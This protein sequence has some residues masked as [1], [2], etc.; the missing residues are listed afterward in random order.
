MKTSLFCRILALCLMLLWLAVLPAHAE[1]AAT[2]VLGQLRASILSRAKTSY[3]EF[4]AN[5]RISAENQLSFMVTDYFLSSVDQEGAMAVDVLVTLSLNPDCQDAFYMAD[6]DFVLVAFSGTPKTPENMLL[7]TPAHVFDVTNERDQELLWP[8]ALYN[9]RAIQLDLVY[10]VASDLTE[11]G[12]LETNTIGTDASTLEAQGPLYGLTFT[13][14]PLDF[15]LINH[16]SHS[17]VTLEAAPLK[18]EGWGINML[19]QNGVEALESSYW[20]EIA[21]DASPFA[22]SA[23]TGWAVRVT[24][25]NGDSATI[26]PVDIQR[27]IDLTVTENDGRYAFE[28]GY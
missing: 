9:D 2:D 3:T 16:T 21:M 25:E 18:T 8:I 7:Y 6:F 20:M 17:I 5:E 26:D 24:F 27:V 28:L 13:R 23:S 19:T 10:E 11:F 1:T 15:N 14:G 4:D 12:F 22:D